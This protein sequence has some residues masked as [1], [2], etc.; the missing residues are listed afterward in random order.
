MQQLVASDNP[1]VLSLQNE[2]TAWLWGGHAVVVYEIRSFPSDNEHVLLLYDSNNT[3]SNSIGEG[4]IHLEET[5]TE[6]GERGLRFSR[7]YAT[8]YDQLYVLTPAISLVDP[9]TAWFT[10]WCDLPSDAERHF[11][12]SGYIPQDAHGGALDSKVS[13]KE[14]PYRSLSSAPFAVL[15]NWAG[16]P[17]RLSLYSPDGS[18]YAERWSTFSP[19]LIQVPNPDSGKWTIKVEAVGVPY[20]DCPYVVVIGTRLENFLPLILRNHG[21]GVDLP[22]TRLRRPPA[23]RLPTMPPTLG[24]LGKR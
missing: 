20:D 16:N 22:N 19:L 8:K 1:A 23:R 5:I 9:N 24:R 4:R 13:M 6:S 7:P 2:W 3:D 11:Q 10:S 21:S 18:L 15:L 14:Y 17:I 12:A